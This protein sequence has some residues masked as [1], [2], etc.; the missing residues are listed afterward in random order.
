MLE[1]FMEIIKIEYLDN[2]PHEMLSL[3]KGTVFHLTTQESYKDIL[4]CGMICNN[5]DGRF[6]LNTGSENSF[7][8]LNGCV[9]FFDLRDKDNDAIN[10][11]LEMYYFLRPTWF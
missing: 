4:K 1:N 11:I 2:S 9:C 7:G 5:K 10:D 8:R 3:L 6:N